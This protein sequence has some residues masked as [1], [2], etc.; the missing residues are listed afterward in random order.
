MSR[1]NSIP[2]ARYPRVSRYTIQSASLFSRLFLCN[3]LKLQPAFAIEANFSLFTLRV[4]FL[5]L[6]SICCFNPTSE[7]DREPSYDLC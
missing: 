4:S 5:L 6:L 7:L 1:N 3:E 2:A